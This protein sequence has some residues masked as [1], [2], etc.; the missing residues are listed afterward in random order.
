MFCTI[1][2][3][4]V[5]SMGLYVTVMGIIGPENDTGDIKILFSKVRD[6]VIRLSTSCKTA[7]IRKKNS[8]I[9][10]ELQNDDF[11]KNTK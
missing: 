8:R 7:N 3:S 1:G 2:F 11:Q 5:L 6:S 4:L 10:P 9:L